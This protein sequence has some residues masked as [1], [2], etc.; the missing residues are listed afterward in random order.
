[1][2]T[3]AIRNDFDF[4]LSGLDLGFRVLGFVV[5][6]FVA[7]ESKR[8]KHYTRILACQRICGIRRGQT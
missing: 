8:N 2:K 1:M 6:G 7:L 5:L 4:K 3:L